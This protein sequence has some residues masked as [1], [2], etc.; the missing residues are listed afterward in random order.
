MRS[1]LFLQVLT[2]VRIKNKKK[3]EHMRALKDL[4]ENLHLIEAPLAQKDKQKIKLME[5]K[6]KEKKTTAQ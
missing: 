1:C 6:S 3:Q 5:G 4:E 2:L